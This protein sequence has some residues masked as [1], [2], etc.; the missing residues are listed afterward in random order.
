MHASAETF[1]QRVAVVTGAGSGIGAACVEL[2][3]KSGMSCVAVD[4]MDLPQF[5][6]AEGVE[7]VT[8]DVGDEGTAKSAVATA[9]GLGDLHTV[10]NI[11]GVTGPPGP[12]ESME[13]SDFD[14]VFAV[15]VR[16]TALMMK[17]ALPAMVDGGAIVNMSSAVGLVGGP[18]QAVYSASKHAVIGLTKSVALDAAPRGIR[19]NCLCPGVVD[20][21]MSGLAGASEGLQEQWASAH[22]IGRYAQPEEIAAAALWLAGDAAGFVT[23]VAMPI[24]GGY[25]A[26]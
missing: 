22:P 2:L 26:R 15:N 4:I 21:P 13:T 11:A 18:S 25:V 14:T 20:T 7:V 3:L 5:S 1:Q 10:F 19:V 16:G 9:V 17:H 23:G 6:G 12:I 24:D 8:G